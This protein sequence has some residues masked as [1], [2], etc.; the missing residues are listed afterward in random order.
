MKTLRILGFGVLA[1]A[2]LLVFGTGAVLVY[3]SRDLPSLDAIENYSPKLVTQFYSSD[4]TL[5]AEFAIER[6][7]P[8]AAADMP[9]TIKNAFIAAEDADFYDHRGVNPVTILRAFLRNLQAGATVQGG[10]T[11]TQQVAKAILLSPERSY[12]RKIREMLLAFQIE[13]SLT[14]EE[15]LNLYL[16]HIYLGE[17]AYGVEAASR[18]F[19]GKGAKELG[20]EEAAILAGLPRAPSRDNPIANPELAKRR[21]LYVLRRLLETGKISREEHA[22]LVTKGVPVKV[23]RP[24]DRSETPYFTEHVRRYIQTKYGDKA[25]YEGGLRVYTTMN[26]NQQLA[27]QAAI[28]TGLKDLDKR[29]GLR[30]PS[31]TLKDEAET[32][33]FFRRQHETLVDEHYEHRVLN[34]K[35]EL[36]AAVGMS[37]PTP[38]KMGRNYPAVLVKKESGKDRALVVQVGNRR[39]IIRPEDLRWVTEANGEEVYKEKLYRNP[40]TELKVGDVL[41]V[42]GKKLGDHK[43]ALTAADEW[44]LEQEPLVQGA[45]LSKRIPDGAIQTLVGGYDFYVTRSEFNRATQAIRQPGSTFKPF[46]FGAALEAGLTPST[47]IVDAPI[48]YRNRDE[49]SEIEKIWR[50]DNYS[51]RFYGDISLR[52]VLVRSLNVPTIKLLQHIGISK[53]IEYTRKLGITAKIQEDLSIALGS[54]AMSLEELMQGWSV[55]ANRGQRLPQ[56]FIRRVEDRAG[57]ILEEHVSQPSETVI[58]EA[59][60]FL[61]THMLKSVVDYGTGVAVKPLGRPVAGKT[62]T[63]NDFKDAWFLGYTPEIITGVWVGFDEDRPLGRNET[64]NRAAA[65]IW[66]EFMKKAVEGT[67][68]KD[69]EMPASVV[70][71]TIDADTGDLPTSRTLKRSQEFF[72][73]GT[74]P[75]TPVGV[76]QPDGGLTFLENQIN[77]TQVVTGNVAQGP[78]TDSTSA[79]DREAA[80][81]ETSDELMRDEF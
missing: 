77:K 9:E 80:D 32:Q 69:F 29:I 63:T 25:F 16:N 50:P 43:T 54:S 40:F 70:Q 56:Y 52:S 58:S 3:F 13:R 62:G 37:E 26:L 78:A 42:R 34:D 35:G 55:Y 59:N 14:K 24:R 53:M 11:I 76:P 31:R 81:R 8:L 73:V 79:A 28:T 27:A 33:E 5:F 18:V 1:A 68:P 61:M 46:I 41:T 15:I 30:K 17:G 21:Q 38:L 47:I 74:A 57:N 4:D 66:L 75:G 12:A 44:F 45:L 65:P 7:T 67:E 22:N 60:A 6:R 19:F 71:V 36:Q 39:G 48:V 20:F 10:S 23:G 64:G 2:A 51:E 49:E 72:A